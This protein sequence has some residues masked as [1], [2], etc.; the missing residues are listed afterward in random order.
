MLS[1]TLNSTAQESKVKTGWNFGPLPAVSYNSDQGFQYGALCDI[2]FFGDGSTFPAY[3]HKFNVEV[4]RYTKG[5]SVYHFFYD[6]RHLLKN[7]RTTADISYLA[8]KMMDFYG[9]NGYWSP[10]YE[11]EGASYYKIDRKLLRFTAD[12][13]GRIN[14]CFDW[15]AGIGIYSYKTGPVQ[16]GEYSGEPNLY[17]NYITAGLIDHQEA[18]GGVKVELKLGVVNDSRDHEADPE[19]GFFSEAI[20][21]ASVDYLRFSLVH[22]GYLPVIKKKMTFAYRAGWQ[23]RLTGEIPFYMLQNISTLYMRQITNEGL[24]GLNSI[25]GVLRNRVVGDG[26]VW[27]NLELRYRFLDFR[28]L[29]QNW[30]LALNPFFDAGRVVQYHKM[31]EMRDQMPDMTLYYSVNDPEKLHLSAGLGGK[32]IMNRNFVISAEWGKPFDS[33]DG[34]NGLNIGLNY[35][36]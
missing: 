12:F 17:A 34:K 35:I 3:V 7:I 5:S 19:K 10:Y 32:A 8:D 6:S 13:R 23:G 20:L 18:E 11:S 28:F 27:A 25:R 1:L 29:G 14:D 26:V 22:R 4:S 36:F 15:A 30:Y 33:R 16:L 2:F 9:F 24:G 21:L 31:D